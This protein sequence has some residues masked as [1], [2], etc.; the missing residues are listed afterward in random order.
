M[1][2]QIEQLLGQACSHSWRKA[3]AATPTS[4]LHIDEVLG[5]LKEKAVL[6]NKCW[7]TCPTNPAYENSL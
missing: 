3:I 4:L 6:N 2:I 5:K 1:P 7:G